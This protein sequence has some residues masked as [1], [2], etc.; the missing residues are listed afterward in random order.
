MIPVEA[1]TLWPALRSCYGGGYPLKSRT[2]AGR[3][4]G[5]ASF[6]EQRTRNERDADFFELRH[7]TRSESTTLICAG[8]LNACDREAERLSGGGKTMIVRGERQLWLQ[9]ISNNSRSCE[10]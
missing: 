1:G 3:Q 9:F 5:A 6:I 4:N 7:R 10:V 8:L 2:R